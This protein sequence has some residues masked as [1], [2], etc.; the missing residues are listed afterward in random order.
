MSSDRIAQLHEQASERYLNGDY[1]GALQA[2]RDVLTMDPRNE[3]AMDGVRMASQFV[4]PQA[5]VATAQPDV[6]NELDRGLKVFDSLG[7]P[8]GTDLGATMILNRDEVDGMID[9]KP[10]P[11][12]SGAPATPDPLRQSEGIDF[13]DLSAVDAIPLGAPRPD[14]HEDPP[15][16]ADADDF[17]LAPAAE[18]SAASLEL[19]RRVGDLL[20]EARAKAD[21]GERDEALTILSRLAILDEDNVEAEVLRSQLQ[22]G[23]S[24]DLDKLEE[25]IIEGVA[26]LESDHLDEAERLFRDALALSPGHREAQHYMEKV[27]QR[28]AGASSHFAANAHGADDL[29]GADLLPGDLPAVEVPNNEAVPLAKTQPEAP[30][31]AKAPRSP[32]QPASEP[33]EAVAPAPASRIPLPPLKWVALGG[34]GAIGLVCA[35]IVLPHLTGGSAK[36]AKNVPVP[37]PPRAAKQSKTRPVAG[38]PATAAVPIT[39]AERSKAVAESVSQGRSRMSAGDFGAA[40]VSFNAALQLDPANVDAKS[41]LNDAAAQYKTQ[42]AQQEALDSI[43]LAFRDGEY[44]AGLRLA[45]RLPPSVP[46][47]FIDG[48]KSA[49]W[50]NLAVVALRAGDCRE[51]LSHLDE[52]LGVVPGDAEAAKLREFATRYSGAPKDRSFLDQVEALSFRSIPKS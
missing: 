5:A 28:R 49:G 3:Q 34:L 48:V 33:L 10:A 41:G 2:W 46:K 21:A 38:T 26:A 6:E 42:K 52:A 19:N 24:S 16:D 17:G 8:A 15:A 25:A 1:D 37:P 47:E 18:T 44:T 31:K 35:A 27:E 50:Y 32:R 43:R 36:S 9:R 23:G 14:G 22:A 29:L 4:A 20:A 51:A 45:Y 40:I 13:G 7:A 11:P 12:E 30:A 39:A